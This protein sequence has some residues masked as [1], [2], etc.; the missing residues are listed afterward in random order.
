[1]TDLPSGLKPH[2]L[3]QHLR[4]Q[5]ERGH[6]YARARKQRFRWKSVTVRLTTLVLSAVSTIIL[7]LQNLD[8]WTGTAFAL[9]A[10]V[11]VVSAL[12]PFF[13]WRS[14][15]VLMEEASYKFHR[16]EDDLSYYVASTP[17]DDVDP[18]RVR[19]MFERYQEIWDS[20]SGRWL[21]F[22]DNG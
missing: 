14:L 21:K 10:V 20:L 15:W 2:E 12:E 18:E 1:M 3:A 4:G 19:E 22:R 16:L 13:A 11:T 8:P 6:A 7:G 5:I 9:V 17:A